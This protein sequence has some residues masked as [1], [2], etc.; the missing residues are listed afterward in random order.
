MKPHKEPKC[1]ECEKLFKVSPQSQVIG[2]FLEHLKENGVKLSEWHRNS[3]V[4]IRSS[5]EDLL[6]EYFDI[7]MDKVERERQALLE[8]LKDGIQLM[9][10]RDHDDKSSR[11]ALSRSASSRS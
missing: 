1:P 9:N 7:D 8:Y 5:T 10:R 4:P 2:A 11:G 3:L 6:A